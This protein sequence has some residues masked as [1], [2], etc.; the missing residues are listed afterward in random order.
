MKYVTVDVEIRTDYRLKIPIEDLAR[1]LNL[2]VDEILEEFAA[3]DPGSV[4]D[5]AEDY[6]G[7]DQ[8]YFL[9]D[10]DDWSQIASEVIDE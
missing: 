10:V 4:T 8:K 6:Q 2:T 1:E 3:D 9:G 5:W 7:I